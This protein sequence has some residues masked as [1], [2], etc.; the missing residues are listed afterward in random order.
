MSAC[1][2]FVEDDTKRKQIAPRIHFSAEDL[3][4]RHIGGCSHDAPRSGC[5]NRIVGAPRDWDTFGESKIEY[6][7]ITVEA[8][9]DVGRLQ[10]AV[11][12]SCGV[13]GAQSFENL[14][15]NLDR[16]VGRTLRELRP[17]Q[18]IPQSLPFDKLGDDE[19]RASW[20][21]SNVVQR[22]NVGMVQCGDRFRLTLKLL[23]E[24]LNGNLYRNGPVESH[25]ASFVDYTHAPRTDC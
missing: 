20:Q 23:T 14:A 17:L 7:H 22:A 21:G 13:R 10:V 1:D 8:D 4:R 19:R 15:R 9:H 12:D 5:C 2:Q 25:V 6:L 3:L 18:P 16:S 11:D 24:L